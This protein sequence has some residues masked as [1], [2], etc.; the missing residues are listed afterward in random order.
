VSGESELVKGSLEGR[1]L[2]DLCT[3][4]WRHSI[5]VSRKEVISY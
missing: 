3:W 4:C 1:R 2:A 5:E